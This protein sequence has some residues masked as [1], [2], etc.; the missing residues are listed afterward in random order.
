MLLLHL[1]NEY[2]EGCIIIPPQTF[3]NK[4]NF[5]NDNIIVIY[6]YI[7]NTIISISEFLMDLRKSKCI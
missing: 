5:A 1:T 3:I 6:F 7:L 2:N 4:N